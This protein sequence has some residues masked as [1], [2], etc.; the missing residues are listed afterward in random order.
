LCS[1]AQVFFL[2]MGVSP[3]GSSYKRTNAFYQIPDPAEV[4]FA[5]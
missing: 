4:I 3:L 1:P 5:H 2:F